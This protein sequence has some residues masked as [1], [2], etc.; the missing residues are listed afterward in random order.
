MNTHEAIAIRIKQLC[1]ERDI[2]PNGL[3]YIAA[4]P[5]ATSKSILN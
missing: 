1:K 4:V 5:Q 3:S 2:T